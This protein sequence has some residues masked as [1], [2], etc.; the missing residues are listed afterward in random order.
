MLG[1]RRFVSLVTLLVFTLGALPASAKCYEI[2]EAPLDADCVVMSHGSQRGVWFRLDKADELRKLKLKQPELELQ[3]F[4]LE[5][6]VTLRTQQV[7][8]L[9]QAM[10][11]QS[12]ALAT[13]KVTNNL[14]VKQK[15]QT[16]RD[17]KAEIEKRQAWYRSPY[18]WFGVGVATTLAAGAGLVYLV[19]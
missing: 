2:S 6:I 8:E 14:L 7:K 13:M 5:K 12:S 10:D 11:S 4:E 3:V 1:F 17:L 9:S 15:N 18:L 19:K 16:D